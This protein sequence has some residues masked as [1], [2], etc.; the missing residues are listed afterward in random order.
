MPGAD[1]PRGALLQDESVWEKRADTAADARGF[2][3]LQ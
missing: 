2:S 3:E 1:R